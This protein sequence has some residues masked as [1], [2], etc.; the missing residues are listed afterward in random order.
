MKNKFKIVIEDYER[1]FKQLK[2][3]LSLNPQMP[4]EYLL[5]KTGLIHPLDTVEL[6]VVTNGD[7][8]QLIA[9]ISPVKVFKILR[10]P[11]TKSV[12]HGYLLRTK[13]V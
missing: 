1:M 7:N 13:S 2:F 3:P 5:G 8:C 11:P 6:S 12:A 9:D 10:N 4:L